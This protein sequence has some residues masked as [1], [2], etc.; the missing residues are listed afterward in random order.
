MWALVFLCAY[1]FDPDQMARLLS[2]ALADP[3][4]AVDSVLDGAYRPLLA[5]C[6]IVGRFDGLEYIAGGNAY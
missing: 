3:C 5:L 1:S 6:I 4:N 2:D